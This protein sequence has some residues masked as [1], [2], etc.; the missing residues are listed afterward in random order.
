MIAEKE[1]REYQY[2]EKLHWNLYLGFTKI[3]KNFKNKPLLEELSIIEK[4]HYEELTHIL[5]SECKTSRFRLRFFVRLGRILGIRFV[6][7]YVEQQENRVKDKIISIFKENNERIPSIFLEN[8]ME[9][10][11]I[12]KLHDE[13]LLY[14][15]AILLGMND[16][17]VEF[18]GALAGYTL[19]VANSKMI[20]IIGMITGIAAALSMSIAEYLAIKEDKNS[21]LNCTRAAIYTGI[22]YIIAVSLLISP[23]FL[24]VN[25][26]VSLALMVFVDIFLVFIFNYYISVTTDEKLWEKFSRMASIVL[27]VAFISFMIGYLVQLFFGIQI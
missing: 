21:H 14:V 22:A 23:Y 15:S 3:A 26:F 17:L 25:R 4:R 18:S 2:L 7:K 19:A 1:I 9:K 27:I 6:I 13:K 10:E 8:D 12:D 16:A 11:L 20:A 5:G 24:D